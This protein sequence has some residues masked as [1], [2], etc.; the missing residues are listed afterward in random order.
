MGIFIYKHTDAGAPV[1][2]AAAGSLLTVLDAVLV[3]GYGAKSPAGWGKAVIDAATNQAVYTQGAAEYVGAPARKV[4]I[5]DNLATA[6]ASICVCDAC[7]VAAS[8]VFTNRY[9]PDSLDSFGTLAK[10][11]QDSG[12]NAAWIMLASPRWFYLFTRRNS[13]GSRGWQMVFAG[14]LDSAYPKD[15]GAMSLL[16]WYS[17]A[18]DLAVGAGNRA[19]ADTIAV[20]GDQSGFFNF[21]Y[22]NTSRIVGD[23]TGYANNT[24]PRSQYAE[25]LALTKVSVMDQ[26]RFRGT[27]PNAYRTLAN[28]GNFSMGM[29]PEAYEAKTAD[30]LRTFLHL[31]FGGEPSDTNSKGRLLLEIT[32]A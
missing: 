4:Y 29:L 6:N 11:D 20:Y 30:G 27:L 13:W 25:G 1:M 9:G 28:I 23:S 8:P 24:S 3:N 5:K 18:G 16:A 12:A 19:C 21:K 26:Y 17:V 7:T 32:G 2:T 31:T 14:D 22:Y 10:A 15:A